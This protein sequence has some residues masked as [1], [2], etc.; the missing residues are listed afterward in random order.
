M[1]HPLVLIVVVAFLAYDAV[2][3]YAS[4]DGWT[5]VHVAGAL[6]GALGA[7]C[8]ALAIAIHVIGRSID[9]TGSVKSVRTADWFMS[10]SRLLIGVIFIGAVFL[11]DWIGVVRAAIGDWVGVDEALASAPAIVAYGATWW[12]FYPIDRRLNEAVMLRALDMGRP[13]HAFPGRWRYTWEKLRFSLFAALAPLALIMLWGEAITMAATHWSFLP[14]P[15]D[16]DRSLAALAG[17]QLVGAAMVLVLSPLLLLTLWDTTALPDGELRHRLEAMCQ[18]HRVRTAGIRV[19]HTRGVILNGAVIGMLPRLRFVLLTDALI[20]SLPSQQLDAVMAH[21]VA[22]VRRR[23]LIWLLGALLGTLGLS[24][25]ALSWALV[26]IMPDR[27]SADAWWLNI[28]DG[29]ILAVALGLTFYVFGFVSRA[30]E[31]E[32]D[33]FAVQD[34]SAAGEVDGESSG[35]VTPDAADAMAGALDSVARL[36]HIP[37]QKHSWRHG[38]IADR[39]RRIHALIGLPITA[40]PAM[41]RARMARIGVLACLIAFAGTLAFDTYLWFQ[42]AP[43]VNAAESER[44]ARGDDSVY[45]DAWHWE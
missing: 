25:W 41:R 4:V 9:R 21:E 1:L 18:R 39:R 10:A 13:I 35:M 15:M 33:A 44:T 38:S 30:F 3:A 23:H 37:Q 31:R 2:G 28:A 26:L 17:L 29:V 19:W 45:Q 14:W 11:L 43:D 7:V 12:I 6:I 22:H 20:E 24:T 42:S 8:M 16:D 27:E 36:N 34:A 32:A 40:L 5:A